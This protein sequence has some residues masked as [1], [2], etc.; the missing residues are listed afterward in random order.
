ML[1]DHEDDGSQDDDCSAYLSTVSEEV[2]R[3]GMEV[4]SS[5][6]ESEVADSVC[7]EL[8]PLVERLRL[9]KERRNAAPTTA[10]VAVNEPSTSERGTSPDALL[11]VAFESCKLDDGLDQSDA[12]CDTS[13][14]Q[15]TGFERHHDSCLATSSKISTPRPVYGAV[16]CVRWHSSTDQDFSGIHYD[17][18]RT[19]DTIHSPPNNVLLEA[20]DSP[21]S[22]GVCD[23][24]FGE[25]TLLL[26]TLADSSMM[27]NTPQRPSAKSKLAT[28]AAHNSSWAE[29]SPGFQADVNLLASLADS[30][31]AW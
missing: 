27:D 3:T 9:K 30:F 6:K 13:V 8:L 2:K 24:S 1:T 4:S 15:A 26:A 19:T 25:D 20:P 21:F 17:S 18:V 5:P 12:G 28:P 22:H 23:M 10:A 11:N 16:N 29:L 14:L 7:E 31:V